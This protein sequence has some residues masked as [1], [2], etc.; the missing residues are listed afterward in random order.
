MY[1]ENIIALDLL[2]YRF[3][4]TCSHGEKNVKDGHPGKVVKTSVRYRYWRARRRL[5]MDCGFCGEVYK[6]NKDDV[7]MIFAE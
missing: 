1:E 5:K 4:C 2:R 6:F 3:G 7:A